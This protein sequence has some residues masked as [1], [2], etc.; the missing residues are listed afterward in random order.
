MNIQVLQFHRLFFPYNKISEVP[1]KEIQQALIFLFKMHGIPLFIKVDNGRP[2]GDPKLELIP[3]LALWLIGL[4]IQVIWNKPKTPQE[5]AKVERGQRTLANWTEY[6]KLQNATELQAKLWEQTDFY[7]CDF[8]IRKF[9][10]KTRIKRYPLLFQVIRQWD[11]ST[12]DFNK[13]IKFLAKGSWERKV[14]KQGQISLY[15]QRLSISTKFK[16]QMIS[17]RLDADKN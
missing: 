6:H 7:N 12:F 15:G 11:P 16:Y 5:N 17:I 14:S 3:V 8:P 10:S 1:I 13:I 2:F 9:Q 4:G